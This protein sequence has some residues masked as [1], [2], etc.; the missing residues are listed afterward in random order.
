VRALSTLP[1]FRPVRA[2]STLPDFR[3][4]LG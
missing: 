2:L 1:D 3:P 4:G